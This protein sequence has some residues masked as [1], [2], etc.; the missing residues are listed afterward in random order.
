MS[1]IFGVSA[2]EIKKYP[3][4]D[5]I[6]T[7]VAKDMF[8]YHTALNMALKNCQDGS[9]FLG[10]KVYRFI[11]GL[12]SWRTSYDDPNDKY[13]PLFEGAISP[14]DYQDDDLLVWE[15]ILP[16]ISDAEF[17]S[18]VADLLWLYRKKKNPEHALIAVE[19]FL[20]SASALEDNR[21]D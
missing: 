13:L 12:T 21:I 10:V 5:V 3:W 17:K 1:S 14:A 19:S 4:Q 16:Q 8:S 15:E 2:D 7:S 6:K 11:G 18:R 9:D 20:M